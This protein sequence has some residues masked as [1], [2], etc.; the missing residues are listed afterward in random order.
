[1][2]DAPCLECGNCVPRTNLQNM[3][4]HDNDRH[5]PPPVG[6]LAGD[7]DKLRCYLGETAFIAMAQNYV[8][9]FPSDYANS[10]W[11]AR[12]LP[13]FL[14]SAPPYC[15]MP[16]LAELALLE[17]ALSEAFN[18]ADAPAASFADLAALAPQHF[19]AAIFDFHPSVQRFRVRT[20][21]TSL[22][23]C[24]MCGELPP[25]PC[26]L[27]APQEILVWRQQSASRFR[28]LGHEEAIVFDAAA[29]ATP[30]TRIIEK[31][32]VMND[33]SMARQRAAG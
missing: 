15:G 31:I 21:V 29:E 7:Y 16:G 4:C 1:M 20:N 23:S 17:L 14:A 28:L 19:D 24:L 26:R 11:Y 10:R 27:V 12:H 30:F 3:S 33:P 2:A 18:A 32:A 13:E 6:L 8:A 5:A 22:W 9:H 25:K